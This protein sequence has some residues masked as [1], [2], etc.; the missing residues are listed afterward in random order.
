[1][2]FRIMVTDN[3]EENSGWYDEK[4]DEEFDEKLLEEIAF[5]CKTALRLGRGREL[6][7]IVIETE[8]GDRYEWFDGEWATGNVI[9]E[10]CPF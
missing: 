3:W 2:H 4:T 7:A 1:M 6:L 8:D 10:R 5:I 9:D